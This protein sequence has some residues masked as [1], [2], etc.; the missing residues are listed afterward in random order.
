MVLATDMKQHFAL[1]SQFNT[2]HRQL[3]HATATATAAGNVASGTAAGGGAA[4]GAGGGT[5]NGSGGNLLPRSSAA[6]L[7][8]VGSGAMPRQ[9]VGALESTALR[10]PRMLGS[11]RSA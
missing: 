7:R 9:G 5:A 3:Q 10:S 8:P 11:Q 1:L 4:S 2:A 6:P